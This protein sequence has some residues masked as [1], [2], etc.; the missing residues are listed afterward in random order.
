M[1]PNRGRSKTK[2]EQNGVVRKV[3]HEKGQQ[4]VR[5]PNFLKEM[6]L[7]LGREVVIKVERGT[8]PLLWQIVWKP[9]ELFVKELEEATCQSNGKH[10][11]SNDKPTGRN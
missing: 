9:K 3:G 11:S 10:N 2:I 8:N 5:L 1:R 7:M 6:G 4:I